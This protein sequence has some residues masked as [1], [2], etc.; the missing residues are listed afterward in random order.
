MAITT[1]THV[2]SGGLLNC[3]DRA[4]RISGRFG[5]W[6][7]SNRLSVSIYIGV[8]CALFALRLAAAKLGPVSNVENIVVP[9][10]APDGEIGFSMHDGV[11]FGLVKRKLFSVR[12]IDG[13]YPAYIE[14]G[15]KRWVDNTLLRRLSVFKNLDWMHSL[16]WPNSYFW[17][18][19]SLISGGQCGVFANRYDFQLHPYS[20]IAGRSFSK[21]VELAREYD[22]RTFPNLRLNRSTVTG[23]FISKSES[24]PRSLIFD[25]L[26]PRDHDR[27]LGV[28]ISANRSI[29]YGVVFFPLLAR[30]ID[31]FNEQS[32][33]ADTHTQGEDRERNRDPISIY[34]RK[35]RE[36]LECSGYLAL[37][38]IL[39]GV[40]FWLIQAA[41]DIEDVSVINM[42]KL[43]TGAVLVGSAIVAG[44]HAFNTFYRMWGI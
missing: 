18:T 2:A 11:V 39:A 34:V 1:L 28:E 7:C 24:Q 12:A 15:M 5:G 40:G 13:F 38:L 25:Q 23:C 21:V 42:A 26:F 27:F 43:G 35:N 8:L 36:L 17:H 4:V 19:Q 20:Y 44:F 41:G 14:L 16:R 31:S 37:Y 33:G 22:R 10:L 9:N 30:P 32:Q 6:W 29:G 3:R